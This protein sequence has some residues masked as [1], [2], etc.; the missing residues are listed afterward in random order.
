[1]TD[2]KAI[3]SEILDDE[4]EMFLNV[5]ARERSSCQENPDGFK[6]YR[7]AMF[8]VWA[9][10]ALE[11]Y[12]ADV[13][14]AKADGINL[15]TL[16]YARMENLIPVLNDNELIDKIVEIEVEWVK[17]IAAKYPHVHRKGKPVEEDSPQAISTRTYLHGE[18]ETYSDKTLE[19]YYQNM[20]ESLERNEN[21]SEKVCAVMVESAGFSSLQTTE[22]NLGQQYSQA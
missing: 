22:E 3:I 1:M 18:L 2:K 6:F 20:L 15:L 7:G 11:S 17:E 4:L 10:K 21:L 16:K 5:N 19:L 13:R 8:S 12:R 14:R 9:I